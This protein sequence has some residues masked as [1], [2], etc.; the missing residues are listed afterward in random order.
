M[1]KL[2]RENLK[3]IR[4]INENNTINLD[5]KANLILQAN[6]IQLPPETQGELEKL[7]KEVVDNVDNRI[8]HFQVTLG[9]DAAIIR[10]KLEADTIEVLIDLFGGN[11][12]DEQISFQ[13]LEGVKL[14]AVNKL[15]A[16]R[17][18][19]NPKRVEF[20]INAVKV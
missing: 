12:V 2:I 15:M 6:G 4:T 1:D 10:T 17:E 18:F 9:R 11:T 14:S 3:R 7:L 20:L 13:T 16:L 19:F 5:G 8:T